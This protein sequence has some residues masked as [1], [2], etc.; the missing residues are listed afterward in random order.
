MRKLTR[1][2]VAGA[3]TAP[4]LLIASAGVAVADSSSFTKYSTK[5]DKHGAWT[6]RVSSHAETDNGCGCGHDNG[7]GGDS[8][9]YHKSK[10]S[11]DKHGA[12]TKSVKSHASTGDNGGYE[13]KHDK[14]NGYD[15]GKN[16]RR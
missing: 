8:S 2:A 14:D 9:S 4:L 6:E 11:A 7:H 15:H 16:D 3:F 12:H 5:A 10:T 1:R 13:G